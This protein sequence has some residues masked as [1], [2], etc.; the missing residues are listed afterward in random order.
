MLRLIVPVAFFAFLAVILLVP[1]WLN[2]RSRERALRIIAEA[3]EKG[4]PLDPAII[5]R[6]LAKPRANVGKGFALLDLVLGVTHF[7]VGIGLAIA[8]HLPSAEPGLMTG[9]LVN[10]CIGLG[11]MTMGAIAWRV[12]VQGARRSQTWNYAGVL[13]L[14]CLYFGVLGICIGAALGMAGV[15]DPGS[16]GSLG[17]NRFIGALVNACYGTGLTVLGVVVLRLSRGEEAGA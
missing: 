9:A 11:L 14:V 7:C 5:D 13:G 4:R 10:L 15:F 16:T 6:M 3:V 17:A 12:F 2:H 8:A 1:A